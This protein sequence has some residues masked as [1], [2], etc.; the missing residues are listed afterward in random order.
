M[1]VGTNVSCYNSATSVIVVD[2]P[3]L[4]KFTFFPEKGADPLFVTFNNKSEYASSY[5]WVFADSVESEEV[6]P[7]FLYLDKATSY[8]KL[9]AYSDHMCADS[10][11]VKI[12]LTLA[13]E[14][15]Q[16]VDLQT[17]IDANGFISN[18]VQ[19]LNSGNV[20]ISNIDITVSSADIPAV[21][22]SWE[23]QL[24]PN[25]VLVYTFVSKQYDMQKSMPSYVCVDAEIVDPQGYQSYYSDRYCID[26]TNDFMIY[27]VSPNPAKREMMLRF[28]TN[29]HG[30]V[31]VICV[32]ETGKIGMKNE[33]PDLE[34]GYHTLELDIMQIPFFLQ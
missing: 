1:E 12:P 16:V 24:K 26:K 30:T 5:K 22:E 23:G 20:S 29:A 7:T 8:A 14:R 21:M 25:E 27:N 11:I 9:I 34:Q 32:D 31:T 33:F 10:V 19:I 4:A 17:T 2:E 13:D 18:T 3:P 15:L 28:S 6:H